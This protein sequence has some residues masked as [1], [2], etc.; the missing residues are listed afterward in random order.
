MQEIGLAGNIN[1]REDVLLVVISPMPTGLSTSGRSPKLI[2]HLVSC[3]T[4]KGGMTVSSPE[5]R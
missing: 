5:D 4:K 3:L 2:I 1:T